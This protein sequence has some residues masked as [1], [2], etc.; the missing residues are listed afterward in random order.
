MVATIQKKPFQRPISISTSLSAEARVSVKKL[1]QKFKEKGISISVEK[2]KRTHE[3]KPEMMKKSKEHVNM[4]DDKDLC[5]FSSKEGLIFTH[6]SWRDE[7]LVIDCASDDF[8]Q[9]ISQSPSVL[10]TRW[11]GITRNLLRFE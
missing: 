6:I 8:D 2:Q 1:V 9:S 3:K 10:H 5:I 4:V 11:H 7:T